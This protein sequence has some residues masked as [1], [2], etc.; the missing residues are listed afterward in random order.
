MNIVT[1][2][3]GHDAWDWQREGAAGEAHPNNP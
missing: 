3:Q 1:E 2:D